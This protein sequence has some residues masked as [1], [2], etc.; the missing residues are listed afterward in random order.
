M[1][2][3]QY[4]NQKLWILLY[5]IFG[6][7]AAV[8]LIQ[9]CRNAI[10]VSQDFQWDAA[11]ALTLRINPY[12]ESLT[13]TGILDQYHW[14]DY[15]LQMEANQFPSLLMLLFPY[16]LLAPLAARY[17]WLASNLLFTVLMIVLLRKTFLAALDRRLF[18]LL[19]LFMISGTPYRNQLGVGQHTIFSFLFFLAAV[20][21]SRRHEES[22]KAGYTAGTILCL[23]VSY[24]KYTLTVPL[25]L[26]FVYKRKWKE[27]I[28][29]VLIHVGLTIFAVFWL[30]TG[31]LDM[32]IQPLQVSSA[33]AAEGGIDFGALLQGSPLAFV[34]AGIVMLFL[35]IM[36]L[37]MPQGVDAQIISMLVLWSLI[38][39]YHRTYDFFVLVVVAALFCGAGQDIRQ[40][41]KNGMLCY[42]LILMV[43]VNYVLRIF[44]EALP[45][46]ICVGT[47]YY[48]FTIWVTWMN[49]RIGRTH[50][51]QVADKR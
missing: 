32:I 37:K 41:L 20:Y 8:S 27:L 12:I 45:A 15:C 40:G 17:V 36:M 28:L 19:M 6:L 13:P 22:G 11:K 10:A 46:L 9:G 48:I 29:S 26:Y 7:L 35:F 49:I 42:Y 38:V 30:H 21:F 50:P 3:K 16:T 43:L 34:L 18:I 14:E 31:I 39:T 25:A 33:L 23:A 1:W 24:F 2:K 44:S 4:E 5:I 47:L 51:E